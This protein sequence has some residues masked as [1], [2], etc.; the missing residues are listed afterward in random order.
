MAKKDKKLKEAKK[1]R[2]AEKAK[3]NEA[4]SQVKDKKKAKKLGDEDDDDQDIDAI[5]E[6]F[7]QEQELF[8]AITVEVCSRP[9]RR[10]NPSMVANPLHGKKELILFGGENHDGV[11][12][13]FYNDLF[14][15]SIDNDTWRKISSKNSPLPRSSHAMCA[16]PS[17]VILMFGG[18]FS[19][20]KQTT[21]YH[22]GDTWI[23]DADTKEWAKIDIKK[24]PSARSGHRMTVWKNYIIL[25]GG[26]RDLGTMSTYMDDMW[27][28]D[29]TTYKWT[30]VEFPPNHPI[31]D[32]RSG[33]SLI[34]CADGA[35]IYGGYTKVKARK[36]LQKGKVL[37]D[38]WLLKMKP[39]PKAI[40]FERRRKQGANPSPRVGCSLVY[41]K[42]RGIMFGGVFDYEES[43]EQIDSDFYNNLYSYQIDSNRWHNMQ[44][45]PRR[46]K[47]I[48]VKEKSRDEDL[49]D[50]LN[51]ILA[52]ASLN[53]DD[54]D[55][56][57]ISK[58][59]LLKQQEEQEEQ[60]DDVKEY[61]IMNQLPHPRFN[62]TICVVDDSLYIL[63]GIFE[64]G[65]QE[66]NLDSMYSIDLGR[67]DGVKVLDRK[68]VV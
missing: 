62:S 11:M 31:P 46:K 10:L 52:K 55:D 61:P 13:H 58:I 56:D 27:L 53:D 63:G 39:D 15:Y 23:L 43:E 33:H 50:I 26:F 32:A 6:Q 18:E 14:T 1:L 34:P 60:E 68:S 30:Q 35:V 42:N 5:L 37:T 36:G 19:S 64:R 45:K 4:K 20:P 48:Q 41:H 66:F 25:H 65:D 9:S 59:E 67:L 44:L 12:S 38:C 28:F 17:G 49:E 22:Y 57:E 54:D 3:K 47:Q 24:G 29:I 7:A 16:H 2:A 21:F 40:R 8:E 51:S